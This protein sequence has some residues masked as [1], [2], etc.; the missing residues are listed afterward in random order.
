MGS[1]AEVVMAG[2]S[3]MATASSSDERWVVR[4]SVDSLASACL[5]VFVDE[6]E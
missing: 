1:E 3:K 5:L 4:G 6:M 2:W